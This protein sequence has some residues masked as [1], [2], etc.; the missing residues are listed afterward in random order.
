MKQMAIKLF[1]FGTLF[2]G[3][4][5]ARA[6]SGNPFGFETNTYPLEYEYCKKEKDPKKSGFRGHGYK[7]SSALRPPPDLQKYVLLFVEDIGRCSISALY[8]ARE[9]SGVRDVQRSDR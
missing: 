1:M 2:M 7:C 4:L 5:D 6:D 9:I 8:L 3:S